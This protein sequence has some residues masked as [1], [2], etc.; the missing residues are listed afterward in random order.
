[1]SALFSFSAVG[2]SYCGWLHYVEEVN[3]PKSKE[4]LYVKNFFSSKGRK[5]FFVGWI[6][7]FSLLLLFFGL[8]DPWF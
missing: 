4:G 7:I 3:K 2:A 8:N 5:Y 6:T 1:M